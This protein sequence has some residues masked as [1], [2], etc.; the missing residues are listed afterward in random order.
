MDG[1]WSHDRGIRLVRNDD[2]GLG[3]TASLDAVEITISVDYNTGSYNG[4]PAGRADWAPVQPADLDSLRNQPGQRLIFSRPA[5][6]SYLMPMVTTRPLDTAAARRA[7][8]LA[9][10]RDAIIRDVFHDRIRAATSLVP[11]LTGTAAEPAL[12]AACRFDPVE[13]RRLAARAGLT[14][15]TVL[16]FRYNDDGGHEA[17]SVAVKRQLETNLGIEV[18]YYGLPFKKIRAEERAPGVSGISR[19]GYTLDYPSPDSILSQLT[20]SAI[21]TTDPAE[22]VSGDNLG[23][24]RNPRFDRLLDRARATVDEATRIALYRQAETVAIGDDLALIP[25]WYQREYRLVASDRFTNLRMDWFDNANLSL[26]SL[27]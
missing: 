25:L 12:C 27:K 15:G 5:G 6:T 20:T 19:I 9:I 21:G 3:A 4:L 13:A 8:S 16:H 17:W 2:Y 23:R 7:I 10:D 26:I 18:N 14:A 24:Y 11:P 22:P 1:P